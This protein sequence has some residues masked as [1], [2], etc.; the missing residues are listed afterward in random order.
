MGRRVGG[1]ELARAARSG[2]PGLVL[3]PPAGA[4]LSASGFPLA[5]VPV[6]PTAATPA[7]APSTFPLLAVL[8][9]L[10]RLVLRRPAGLG[11]GRCALALLLPLL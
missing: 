11:L 5:L 3:R 1:R 7:A 9:W 2:M 6:A 8:A 10:L 4:G